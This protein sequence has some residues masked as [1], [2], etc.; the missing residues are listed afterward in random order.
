MMPPKKMNRAAW[1][2]AEVGRQNST[3]RSPDLDGKKRRRRYSPRTGKNPSG[4][5]SC[6]LAAVGKRSRKEPRA[7]EGNCN[8]GC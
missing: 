6:C 3:T 2:L 7:F 1:Q 8:K 4:R 5:C